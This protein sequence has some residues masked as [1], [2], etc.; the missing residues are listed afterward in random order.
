MKVKYLKAPK[1]DNAVFV[2]SSEDISRKTIKKNLEDIGV[3]PVKLANP[4]PE[5]LLKTLI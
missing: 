1:C 4:F 3:W 2:F 5:F